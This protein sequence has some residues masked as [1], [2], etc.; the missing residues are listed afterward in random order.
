MPKLPFGLSI[1][2]GISGCTFHPS[3]MHVDITNVEITNQKAPSIARENLGDVRLP[4]VEISLTGNA[5]VYTTDNNQLSQFRCE[6]MNGKE[7][8]VRY[9]MGQLG[10]F[11]YLDSDGVWQDFSLSDV[12]DSSSKLTSF[13]AL[14][15]R[16]LKVVFYAREADSKVGKT[17]RHDLLSLDF[18][19]V[20]CNVVGVTWPISLN[21]S[22]DIIITKAQLVQSYRDF[23]LKENIA[24]IKDI[25][26]TERQLL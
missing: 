12:E 7:K 22:N 3:A 21:Y 9:S 14:V 16:D 17:T 20:Q 18:T 11:I 1:I 15:Y 25:L 6:V 24:E 10:D 2:M 4:T 23:L 19:H 26:A 8:L 5:L 13:S